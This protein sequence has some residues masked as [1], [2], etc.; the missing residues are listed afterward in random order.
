MSIYP[1][2]VPLPQYECIVSKPQTFKAPLTYI[3]CR[4]ALLVASAA[5]RSTK[6]KVK[7]TDDLATY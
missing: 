3:W 2:A 6:K 4:C 7:K 5:A 1:S